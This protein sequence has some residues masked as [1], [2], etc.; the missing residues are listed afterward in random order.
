MKINKSEFINILQDKTDLNK[1]DCIIVNNILENNLLFGNKSKHKILND[2]V[3][4]LNITENRAEEIYNISI[5]IIL[6]AIKEKLKNPFKS[7][8]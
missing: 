8:D 1:K 2:L 6:L 5:D 7:Q 3:D 4:R